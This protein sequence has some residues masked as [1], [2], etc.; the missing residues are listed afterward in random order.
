MTKKPKLSISKFKK[1]LSW[2]QI[3]SFVV[4]IVI[5]AIF[6]AYEEFSPPTPIPADG[7][8][9]AIYTNDARHNL[10][11]LYLNALDHAKESIQLYIY[12]LTDGDFAAKLREK[13]ESGIHV[14]L[15]CD[16]DEKSIAKTKSLLGRSV[17]VIKRQSEGLM[18]LKILIIDN[19][20]VLLGSANM[21]RE[22]LSM[23]HNNVCVFHSPNLANHLQCLTEELQRPNNLTGNTTPEKKFI[24]GDQEV[25]LWLLSGNPRASKR[26]TKLIDTAQKSIKVA[27]YTFTRYDL[28]HALLR[29]QKRGVQVEV[30]MDRCSASNSSKHI[31]TLMHYQN[32]PFKVSR[33]TPLLHHKCMIVDDETFVTGSTNWTKR[34][35][36]DN[37]DCFL[38]IHN[39]LPEQKSTLKTLWDN[40]YNECE[41]Y[42]YR[43]DREAA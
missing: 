6:T 26:L 28:T 23:H 32:L 31:A 39:L 18:H 11:K 15:I 13:A 17:N 16:K 12:T 14:T 20:E 30:A 34:A 4:A 38:V 24:I 40:L 41:Q 27:M 9:L 25:E 1:R 43:D 2:P 37:D 29:A 8:P 35:F 21:T 42:S 19:K 3:V 5:A 10:K 36:N 22:S 7:E 33:G